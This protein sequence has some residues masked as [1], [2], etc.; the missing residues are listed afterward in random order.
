MNV[1]DVNDTNL[2]N[3]HNDIK[4]RAIVLFHHPQC[5]HCTEL[6]PTWEKVK[7]LNSKKPIKIIEINAEMLHKIDHPIKQIV[8]GFPQIVHLQNGEVVNEFN[9]TRNVENLNKFVNQNLITRNVNHSLNK[10]N[11]RNTNT[12]NKRNKRNT[13]KRNTKKRNTKKR[14]NARKKR[15]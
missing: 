10:R 13:K 4:G 1:I 5:G 9:Q 15:T 14:R 11:T 3:F 8:Q 6:R 12:R 7:Q 2:S